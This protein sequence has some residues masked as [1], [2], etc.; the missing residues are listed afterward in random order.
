MAEPN[1]G[2]VFLLKL[3]E[4]GAT[5]KEMVL[6]LNNRGFRTPLQN[7]LWS[8]PTVSEWL[9]AI[10]D[11][12]ALL[13]YEETGKR[14]PR[15]KLKVKSKAR[16]SALKQAHKDGNPF[17]PLERK[18]VL[19]ENPGD[20]LTIS[21]IFYGHLYDYGRALKMRVVDRHEK[22]VEYHDSPVYER[23]SDSELHA[24]ASRSPNAYVRG[25]AVVE[26]S[27]R[28]WLKAQGP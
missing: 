13:A 5:Q 28:E 17:S 24:L 16:Q 11:M 26:L 23:Y 7:A 14:V 3:K 27:H 22:Y 10:P 20:P 2:L 18:Y 21:E 19:R 12:D 6:L 8:Q 1:L 9:R 15:R 4:M 25:A